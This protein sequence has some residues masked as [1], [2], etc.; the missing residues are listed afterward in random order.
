MLKYVYDLERKFNEILVFIVD[1]VRVIWFLEL[2]VGIKYLV[3]LVGEIGIF[4]IVI[5]VNFFRIF[6]IEIYVRL[7]IIFKLN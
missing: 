1:I 7:L 4:K 3:V 2:M 6:S 5:I